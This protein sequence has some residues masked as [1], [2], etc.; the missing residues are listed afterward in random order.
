MALTREPSARRA[1]T[2]GDASSIRRPTL[3]HDPLD[4]PAQVLLVEEAESSSR[5]L[6]AAARLDLVG[7]VDHDLG[8][9]V[10]A[11]ERLERA[12]A[13][14]VVGDLVLDR[15]ALVGATA[16]CG[17]GSTTFRRTA[18]LH[19]ARLEVVAAPRAPRR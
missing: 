18:R 8:D 19:V 5:E 10:V 11:E 4:D 1:S 6:A 13:E 14:H 9:G 15:R 16:A 12:V 17:R 3:R 2:I 7:A